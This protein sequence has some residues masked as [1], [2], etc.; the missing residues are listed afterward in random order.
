M[1]FQNST[2][3]RLTI[4]AATILGLLSLAESAPATV[5]SLNKSYSYSVLP[6][7][8]GGTYYFDNSPVP[9]SHPAMADTF[10]PGDLSDGTTFTGNPTA[11]AISTLV[12]WDPASK[13]S[14][15]IFDLDRLHVLSGVRV[16]ASTYAEF[17]NGAPDGVKVSLSQ[18]GWQPGDFGA[19]VNAAF[20]ASQVPGS[21]HYD[22]NVPLGSSYARFVKLEFDGGA[23]LTGGAP[24]K[25]MLD[26]ISIDGEAA[27]PATQLLASFDVGNDGLAYTGIG[28]AGGPSTTF[29]K[30]SSTSST[31]GANGISFRV[32]NGTGFSNA[33]V[34]NELMDDYYYQVGGGSDQQGNFQVSGLDDSL[35]YDLYLIA[36]DGT[37]WGAGNIYGADYIINGQTQ[38]ATG[39][40]ANGANPVA[41]WVDG[42]HYARF[43]GIPSIGGVIDGTFNIIT[44]QPHA[45]IAGLQVVGYAVPEPASWLLVAIGL[46]FL[47][48]ARH[49]NTLA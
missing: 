1:H 26:E 47:A 38:R 49:R 40:N 43:H 5:V 17:G 22:L 8:S 23:V 45:G 4:L 18:G 36:S 14:T 11:T 48:A 20:T 10:G 33:N 44:G 29:T 34:G 39:G 19:P 35:L 9:I 41:V 13:A 37:G 32:F 6:G 25:W 30:V 24:N 2:A 3:M 28:P 21:A 31:L 42:I 16:G 7:F 12:G 27:G 46:A 15:I